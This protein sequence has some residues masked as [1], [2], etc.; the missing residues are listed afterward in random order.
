MIRLFTTVLVW[1]TTLVP[2]RA[3]ELH[4]S[5]LESVTTIDTTA[6]VYFVPAYVHESA[7]EPGLDAGSG[8]VQEVRLYVPNA[9][10]TGALSELPCEIWDGE[11]TVDGERFGNCIPLPLE[12]QGEVRLHI[13]CVADIHISGTAVRLEPFREPRYVEEF[14]GVRDM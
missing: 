6:I 11:L 12:R 13:E 5:T 9:H 4:D 14:P 3:I 10:I 2:S 8:W 7:G 1:Q